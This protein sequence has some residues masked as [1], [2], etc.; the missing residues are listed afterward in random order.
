MH[1]KLD[2]DIYKC[3]G[4]PFHVESA[5]LGISVEGNTLRQAFVLFANA[6]KRVKKEKL[7]EILK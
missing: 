7:E 1:R 4:E 2:V 5:E 6:L 3:P